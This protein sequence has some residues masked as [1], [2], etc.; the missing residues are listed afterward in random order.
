VQ[1]VKK[2]TA[3]QEGAARKKLTQ[4]ELEGSRILMK[5]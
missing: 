5:I 1:K 4:E 2:K 3:L